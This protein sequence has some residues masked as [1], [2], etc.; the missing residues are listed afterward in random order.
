MW[1]TQSPEK[2]THHLEAVKGSYSSV[3]ARNILILKEYVRVYFIVDAYL[4]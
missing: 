1:R 2:Q 3:G 4:G